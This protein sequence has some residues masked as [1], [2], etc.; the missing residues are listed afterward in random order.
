MGIRQDDSLLAEE[1]GERAFR[2][3]QVQSSYSR[4]GR[5]ETL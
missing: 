3:N 1:E 2:R 4:R 5:G